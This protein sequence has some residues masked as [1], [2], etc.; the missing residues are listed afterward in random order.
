MSKPTLDYTEM[1]RYLEPICSYDYGLG[2]LHDFLA[3]NNVN[4]D[5]DFQRVHVWTLQQRTAYMEH[6][7]RGGKTALD[8]YI[9]SPGW[10]EGASSD[11]VLVDGKQRVETV[12]LFIANEVPIFGGYLL[13]D[14]TL[15]GKEAGRLLWGRHTMKVHVNDLRTRA[16]VL[17]WYLDINAGGTPHTSEEIWKVR[18]MLEESNG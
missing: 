6:I 14:I 15:H 9:N 8:I 5:P 3:R 1:P 18:K 4:T 11:A 7:F 10:S 13:K 17:Q 2:D 16:E 12:R